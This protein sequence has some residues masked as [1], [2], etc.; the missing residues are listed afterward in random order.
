MATI[1]TKKYS[2]SYSIEDGI[3]CLNLISVIDSERGK[4]IGRKAMNRFMKKF[5]AKDIELHAYPQDEKTDLKKLL[6]FYESF[7]FRVTCGDDSFGFEMK[8]Y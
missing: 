5:E 3:V 8:N 6:C 7:G 2:L 4:G 1:K